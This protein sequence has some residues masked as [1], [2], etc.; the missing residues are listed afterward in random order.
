MRAESDDQEPEA[1]VED[2]E[3]LVEGSHPVDEISIDGM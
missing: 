2:S 3:E 1:P